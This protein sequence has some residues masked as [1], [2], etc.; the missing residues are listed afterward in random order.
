[1]YILDFLA[2]NLPNDFSDEHVT[3]IIPNLAHSNPAVVLSAVKV[4]LT[5]LERVSDQERSKSICRKMAPPLISLMNNMP[6]IQYIA[7]RNINLILIRHPNIFDRE[8]R[9]F[10]CNF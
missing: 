9:V 1:M 4:I 2:E 10:F 8:V 5:L 7:A 3:R 6:E